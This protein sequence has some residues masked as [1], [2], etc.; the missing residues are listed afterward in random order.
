MAFGD[1]VPVPQGLSF[2]RRVNN[3]ISDQTGH[4]EDQNLDLDARTLAILGKRQQ[5]SVRQE[6]Q[7]T[8]G[9]ANH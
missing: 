4:I 6:I 1:D 9:V 2:Q 5:L 7:P 3:E 8:G